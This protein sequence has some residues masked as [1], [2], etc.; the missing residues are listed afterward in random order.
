LVQIGESRAKT[1][2]P[3]RWASLHAR[4]EAWDGTN[5][6]AE[7]E[8]IAHL[9][10]GL[11]MC[12]CRKDWAELLERLPPDLSSPAAYLAWTVKAHDE[13]NDRLGKP[14]Y[15]ALTSAPL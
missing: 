14:V 1:E 2:G 7:S 12:S 9:A 3:K 5:P 13:V 8:F 6:D 15:S 11:G 4:A 10:D